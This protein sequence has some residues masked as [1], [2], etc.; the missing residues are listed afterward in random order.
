MK[1]CG[2]K[3]W[4]IFGTKPEEKET[5]LVRYNIK[6]VGVYIRRYVVL[7]AWYGAI[8]KIFEDRREFRTW[9]K[10]IKSGLIYEEMCRTIA[11]GISEEDY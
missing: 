11:K 2:R 4:Y 3:S 9:V 7:L 6:P 5:K 10:A 8:V 1:E